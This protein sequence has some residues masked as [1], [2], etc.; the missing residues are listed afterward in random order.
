[1]SD[2]DATTADVAGRPRG[3][4]LSRMAVV[5]T[6]AVVADQLTKSWAVGRLA[7]RTIDVAWTLR[8]NLTFNSGL[9]FGQGKGLTGYITVIG[10]LLVAALLWWSRTI[11]S[12]LVATA[13]GLMIGGASGN[14]V[15]RLFRSHG[16]A[17]IDFIDFQW[18]PVFNVADMAVFTGAALLILGTLREETGS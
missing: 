1:V 9:S 12:P 5:A 4:L 8:F 6:I 17:V 15:D 11:A 2:A 7:D 16:G 10:V 13:V 14:L 3:P 18:W